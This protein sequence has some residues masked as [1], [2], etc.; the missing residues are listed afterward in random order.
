MQNIILIGMPGCG[1]TTVGKLLAA[2]LHRPFLDS[3]A[4]IVK[5][6]GCEIPAF[7]A[8]EGEA[9]FRKVESDD[10]GRSAGT[11]AARSFWC[12]FPS[13]ILYA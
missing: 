11:A 5:R 13:G 9:A 2:R 1:K 10:K 4:E 12:D 7:F 8:R 6:L 3:D